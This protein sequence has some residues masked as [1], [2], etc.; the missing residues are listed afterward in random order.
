MCHRSHET[1]DDT[2]S[3]LYADTLRGVRLT[4]FWDQM[5]AQFGAAYARSVAKDYV[6]AG[7][8]GRTVEQALAEGV[9][10]A[11][12]WRA[13]CEAFEVPERLRLPVPFRWFLQRRLAEVFTLSAAIWK[14]TRPSGPIGAW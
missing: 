9:D 6:L 10:V 13:V 1:P 2:L 5:G 4:T 12:V 8:G 11:V 3:L 14:I 7:L